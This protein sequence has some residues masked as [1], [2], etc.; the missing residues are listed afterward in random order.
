M[1]YSETFVAEATAS[2]PEGAFK[3]ARKF[4]I[5]Y[6]GN[7]GYT[8][9]IAEK[10]HFTMATDKIMGSD[11]AYILADQLSF[12]TYKDKW[13]PAGC[14]QLTSS[15]SQDKNLYLFFGWASA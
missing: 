1:G 4:A 14:I 7:S 11:E 6:H 10:S 13:G 9:T 3:A 12:T 2:T 8:G 5:A 15:N